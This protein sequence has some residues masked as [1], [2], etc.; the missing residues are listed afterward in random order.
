MSNLPEPKKA[1]IY[2]VVVECWTYNKTGPRKT[3][4]HTIKY[5]GHAEFFGEEDVTPS[6]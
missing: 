6:A 5:P 3:Y 1:R 4:S 2:E